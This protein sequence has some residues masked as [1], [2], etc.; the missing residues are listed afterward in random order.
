MADAI[1]IKL[2]TVLMSLIFKN[3]MTL[4]VSMHEPKDLDGGSSPSSLAITHLHIGRARRRPPN[5]PPRSSIRRGAISCWCIYSVRA[6]WCGLARN[7]PKGLGPAYGDPIHL[8]LIIQG[9]RC[10]RRE[11]G[12]I[13]VADV[14][15]GLYAPQLRAMRRG[16]ESTHSLPPSMVGPDSGFQSVGQAVV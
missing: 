8:H 2:L 14:G 1:G 13:R 3:V 9:E 10:C 15:G 4:R 6:G 11:I 12:G 5:G 16:T 7:L